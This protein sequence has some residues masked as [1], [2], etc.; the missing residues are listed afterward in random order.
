MKKLRPDLSIVL[1]CLNEEKTLSKCILNA[2]ECGL[3]SGINIEIVVADNGSVDKS[4]L[5][6]AQEA[7]IFVEVAERGYGATL[8]A[9]IR[10]A[11]G[12]FVL[13][14]D[15]DLSYDFS[16]I[17]VFFKKLKNENFDLVVGN[18]FKGSIMPGAMPWHHKYIGNPALSFVGRLFFTSSIGDFHC[19]IRAFRKTSY[20]KSNPESIGMEYASEMIIRFAFNSMKITEIPVTLSKDGRDRKPHL[21]SF[22]DGWRHLKLMLSLAP[23]FTLLLPGALMMLLGPLGFLILRQDNYVDQSSLAFIQEILRCSYLFGTTI[24][25]L[26]SIDIAH[27]KSYGIGKFKWLPNNNSRIRRNVVLFTPLFLVITGMYT[28]FFESYIFSRI[29]GLYFLVSGCIFLLGAYLVQRVLKS[30]KLI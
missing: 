8:D 14:A 11:N 9:G 15:S 12:D 20:L 22:R 4:R 30:G 3:I 13:I 17:A 28:V 2:R 26:G 10:A 5:I 16:L 29:D 27:K 23:Q 25:T 19:G 6:A 18:R 7:D 24:F 21:R 1:P